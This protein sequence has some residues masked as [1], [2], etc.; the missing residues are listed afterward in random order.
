MSTYIFNDNMRF[1]YPIK[2]AL[3][4]IEQ[5]E[6]VYPN[7]FDDN[8]SYF[9]K[10]IEKANPYGLFL[11]FG[12]H[13]GSSIEK[14]ANLTSEKVYG[15][16]SFEGIPEKWHNME[17]HA[18]SLGGEV[19][20][21]PLRS[22]DQYLDFEDKSASKETGEWPKN[23]ELIKGWFEDSVPKFAKREEIKNRKISFLHIDCDLYTSTKTIFEHLGHLIEEG[24]IIAFDEIYGYDRFEEHEAFAF[25]EFLMSYDFDYEPLFRVRGANNT[26]HRYGMTQGCFRIKKRTAPFAGYGT[27]ANVSPRNNEILL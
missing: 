6:I 21:G 3:D 2:I 11:E 8:L 26:E 27:L 7:P 19:P 25:A 17:A 16:D 15:F 22:M 4:L 5:A 1:F 12:V 20:E 10:C 9:K 24:T 13:R 23:I 14:I 18:F